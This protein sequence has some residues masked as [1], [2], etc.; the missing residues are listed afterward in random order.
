MIREKMTEAENRAQQEAA[1]TGK[2]SHVSKRQ[3][4][5][6]DGWRLLLSVS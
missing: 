6:T 2:R 3:I 1:E 5:S 4:H